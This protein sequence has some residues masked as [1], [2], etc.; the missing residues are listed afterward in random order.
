LFWLLPPLLLAGSSMWRL[1][2]LMLGSTPVSLSL[3]LSPA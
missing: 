1:Q 2:L 3:L